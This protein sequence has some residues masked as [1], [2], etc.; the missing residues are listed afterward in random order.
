MDDPL[1]DRVAGLLRSGVAIAP[2]GELKRGLDDALRRLHEPLRVAIAGKVKAGKSTLLNALV[3]ERLAPTDAGE[4]TRIVTWYR[5][6]E[7]YRAVVHPL[8]GEPSQ[9]RFTRDDGALDVDLGGRTP[10]DVSHLEIWWPS[11]RLSAM[12][13]LDM[14]GTASISTH[15]SARTEKALLSDDGR[16][17]VADAVI[18]LL[19]HLHATD[20]H[21]LE[22]FHDDEEV[23]H[24]TPTTAI[25]VL[26]RADEIGA[27]RRDALESAARVA[28]RYEAEPSL[29]RLCRVVV[30]V[31]GLIAQAGA[32]LRE[33]EF[34]SIAR[35]SELPAEELVDLLL[36]ADRF[37]TL[38][39]SRGV[40]EREREQ[41]VARL[42]IF[43]VRVS[44][45]YVRAH[46]A[47]S[48]SELASALVALSGIDRLRAVLLT[49]FTE[50]ARVLKA[51]SAV[52]ALQAALRAPEWPA[53]QRFQEQIELLVTGAHEFVEVSVIDAAR[54][55]VIPLPEEDLMELERLLGAEGMTPAAR[56]GGP[57]DAPPAELRAIAL[58]SLRRWRRVAARPL[59]PPDVRTAAGAAARTCEGLITSLDAVPAL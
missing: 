48:A 23:G 11:S 16:P 42:G 34:Q 22:S 17:A 3:G 8:E 46:R 36:S 18:Y 13:L 57:R 53:R 40:P 35:L 4:C 49:Q 43:G 15:V 21:F 12:T 52:L 1:L 14:P 7:T 29:R 47:P 50:R 6:G 20:M 5:H 27:C 10:E 33:D 19:R 38:P 32:T 30:P 25:G 26:S 44:V 39:N 51:R 58:D 55:G 28:R 41:L 31:A 9:A 56:L 59:A 37:S 45:E 2:E 24:S 54:S